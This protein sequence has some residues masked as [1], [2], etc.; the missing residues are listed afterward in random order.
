MTANESCGYKAFR[1]ENFNFLPKGELLDPLSLGKAVN[2]SSLY[3][4]IASAAMDDNPVSSLAPNAP[5]H[6]LQKRPTSAGI[7]IK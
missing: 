6:S 3:N 2:C 7:I 1:E 5:F 4:D